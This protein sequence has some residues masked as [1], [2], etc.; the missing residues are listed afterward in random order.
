LAIDATALENRAAIPATRERIVDYF[1]DFELIEEIARGGMGVVYRARQVSLNRPVALKLILTGQLAT[2]ALK[3]RF[4]TEAEAAA[5]LDHPNIVPIYEIGELDQQPYLVM[6]LI[7]GPTVAGLFAGREVRKAGAK[8]TCDAVS[9]AGAVAQDESEVFQKSEIRNRQSRGARLISKIARAVHY[10]HQRGILH[11]DLKPTNILLDEHGEPHVTDFGLAKL[12]DDDTGLTATTAV[13]GTP[14]YMS[15]EQASGQ[16]KALT[17]ATDIYSLGAILYELLTGQLPFRAQTTVEVLRQVCE[18]E[19]TNPRALNPQVD[20]DLAIICLKCLNKDP[21]HR[22][23]SAEMLAEDLERWSNGEA[24]LARPGTAG[25][26]IRRWTRRN[27][28]IATLAACLV[29]TIAAGLIGT[30]FMWQRARRTADAGEQLL[31]AASM[32]SAQT[33]WEENNVGLVR[34]LLEQTRDSPLRGFEW[35]YWQRLTHLEVRTFRGHPGGAIGVAIS[36]DGQRVVSGGLDRIAKVWELSTGRELLR[37][38]GHTD[39]IL[40]VAFSTDGRRIVTGSEDKTARV[41]DAASGRQLLK[42]NGH[43]HNVELVAFSRDDQRIVTGGFDRTVRLWE[44]DSGRKVLQVPGHVAAL[45][46][47]GRRIVTTGG[48]VEVGGALRGGD[49]SRIATLWDAESGREL[50][51]FKGHSNLVTWVFF[52]RDGR[53]VATAS[54][55]STAKLWDAETGT[56]LVTLQGHRGAIS[57]VSFSSDGSRVVTTSADQTARI[58]DA[59]TGGE[60]QTLKGHSGEII[61]AVFSPDDRQVVTASLDGT[62]KVWDPEGARERITL[63]GETPRLCGLAFSPDGRRVVTGASNGQANLWDVTTGRVL[64][65]IQGIAVAFSPDGRKFVTTYFDQNLQSAAIWDPISGRQGIKFQVH[66][67]PVE[68]I[69]FSP[70]GQRIVTCSDDKTPIVWEVSSGKKLLE[71]IGHTN[72]VRGC[73]FSPDGRRIVTGSVDATVRIWDSTN[74]AELRRFA[75]HRAQAF[76]VTFSPDGQRVLSGDGTGGCLL[77]EASSGRVLRRFKGHT[78]AIL[79][80]SFSPDGRRVLTGSDDQS[81][82]LWETAS[83]REMLTFKSHTG[84]VKA[85]IFAPDGQRIATAGF[86][87]LVRLWDSATTEQVRSWRK[88]EARS[89]D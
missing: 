64:Q 63:D 43:T 77:W 87:G 23:G 18:L 72:G 74:G 31:Y 59:A 32:K 4:H 83:G 44:A 29:A 7:A 88:E 14:A 89:P 13:L 84:F 42:L 49:A 3:Q 58:W 40:S 24:I 10:A 85:A 86:D 27:P 34:E 1:G 2:P 11:R 70:D 35:Y 48:F 26:R 50:L 25:E 21:G 6:K 12:A 15:P 30:G 81:A 9:P 71:L 47:D 79:C 45:S 54:W 5:R 55:D 67:L 80:A 37:L 57:S 33:A 17:T 20:R 75:E 61:S 82:K 60:L 68:G 19:P 8:A 62:V 52:S 36:P 28:E 46:P 66:K 56:N 41:W 69:A 38:E 78:A 76:A 22:Y 16:S 51:Q 73:A 39:N 65:R 53:R